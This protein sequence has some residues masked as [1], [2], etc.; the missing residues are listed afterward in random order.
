MCVALVLN[1][2]WPRAQDGPFDKV[3][4]CGTCISSSSHMQKGEIDG[5]DKACASAAALCVCVWVCER[6]MHY[7]S[8]CTY[9]IRW[10]LRELRRS[11]E[12]R[13]NCMFEKLFLDQLI[14]AG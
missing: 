12:A 2:A 9:L 7:I 11:P 13:V 5:G 3:Q 1:N 10:L 4:L 14:Q 8:I 6:F